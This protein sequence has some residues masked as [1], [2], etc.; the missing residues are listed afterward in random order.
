MSRRLYVYIVI[1]ECVCVCVCVWHLG[2]HSHMRN[3]HI[4]QA[5]AEK[6]NPIIMCIIIIVIGYSWERV[7]IKTIDKAQNSENKR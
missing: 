6:K 1:I 3:N 5:L 7:T 4:A 2:F